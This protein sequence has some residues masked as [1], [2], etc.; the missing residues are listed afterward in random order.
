MCRRKK[1]F[2]KYLRKFYK[3]VQNSESSIL[4]E[5]ISEEYIDRL[6]EE[7]EKYYSDK[8]GNEGFNSPLI[9]GF[10]SLFM[11]D[12]GNT[13]EKEP[14]NRFI[15]AM[16]S[17]EPVLHDS[18]KKNLKAKLLEL[19]QIDFKSTKKDN[20]E[21]IYEKFTPVF[22][23]LIVVGEFAKQYS[24]L[25]IDVQLSEEGSNV[26]AEFKII[27]RD[28]LFE[29]TIVLRKLDS[30]RP[31]APDEAGRRIEN[32]IYEKTKYGK[33]LSLSER[34]SILVIG[35]TG[36]VHWNQTN[37]LQYAT[38][39]LKENR[40]CKRLNKI[41]AIIVSQSELFN[42]GYIYIWFNDEASYPLTKEE[43]DLLKQRFTDVT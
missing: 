2:I 27:E 31:L 30:R 19:I 11:M 34:P 21:L 43:Q 38:K 14:S 29:I 37:P 41:S 10:L 32:K 39:S 28:I 3:R 9:A 18:K 40:N 22:Y 35:F 24:L 4:Q 6:E 36:F 20:R 17:I 8:S 16:G 23:E 25:D 12:E 42:K 13:Q 33:Q 7:I 1:Q 26:D 15:H 5:V